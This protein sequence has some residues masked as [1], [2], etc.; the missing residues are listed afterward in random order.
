MSQEIDPVTLCH[1]MSLVVTL[2]KDCAPPLG[3][4]TCT[5]FLFRESQC[6]GELGQLETFI[7]PEEKLMH[8]GVQWIG[9]RWQRGKL[10]KEQWTR[11]A[12]RGEGEFLLW[13]WLLF[14]ADWLVAAEVKWLHSSLAAA[15]EKLVDLQDAHFALSWSTSQSL[16]S[17]MSQITALTR[18]ATIFKEELCR[19]KATADDGS[20]A[21][22]ELQVSDD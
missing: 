21:F 9:G 6:G 10:G 19:A 17:Q 4:F 12:W 7:H 15:C 1:S 5:L 8:K 13:W 2:T 20:K 16:S 18:Q 22:A 11:S 3:G 14:V